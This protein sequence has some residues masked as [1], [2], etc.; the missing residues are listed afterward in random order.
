MI[1]FQ[2]K[3]GLKKERKRELERG[4][5]VRRSLR[6]QQ[7]K[8]YYKETSSEEEVAKKKLKIKSPKGK[9]VRFID[10]ISLETYL[11]LKLFL[12]WH[13]Q[14]GCQDQCPFL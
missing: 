12:I 14:A 9:K 5:T 11:L 13:H 6:T 2:L 4:R 1:V 3:K 10:I 8:R 7:I